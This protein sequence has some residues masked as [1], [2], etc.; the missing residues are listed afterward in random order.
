MKASQI[1]AFAVGPVANALLGLATLPLV[2]WL[3]TPEDVG[4]MSMLN[5][6]LSFCLLFC[7]LGL[8]QAYVREFHAETH[9]GALFKKVLLPGL[10]VLLVICIGFTLV[11]G[12]LTLLLTGQRDT[13]LSLLI[14]AGLL[15]AFLSR[16]LSLILRMQGRGL[17]FSLSQLMPR[18]IMLCATGVYTTFYTKHTLM[19]LVSAW[20]LGLMVATGV[21]IWLTPGGWKIPRGSP[22]GSVRLKD[23][24]R[25]GLPLIPGGMAFWGASTIDRVFVRTYAGFDELAVFSVAISV[26]GVAGILQTVFTTVWTPVIYQ[27]AE[28]ADV[29]EI[30]SKITRWMTIAVVSMFCIVGL[31]SWTLRYILPSGYAATGHILASCLGFPLLLTLSE[32]TSVGIGL[33]RKTLYLLMASAVT[34]GVNIALNAAL[35]PATGAGGAAVAT[36]LS[37]W[38]FLVLRTEFSVRVWQ[39][40][41]RFEAYIF[42]LLCV[43]AA[44]MSS[45]TGNK[46][47][48]LL[49]GIWLMLLVSVLLCNRRFI[50]AEISSFRQ[51]IKQK[52][53]ESCHR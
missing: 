24:L 33:R 38:F 19:Q 48:G 6:A 53:T 44:A 28:D 25:F 35:V 26:A 10:V 41:P 3:F 39:K 11:P 12:S 9:R 47:E 17:A 8:D 21:L 16:F 31:L 43:C 5:V 13:S 1:L 27:R 30:V 51:E 36:S 40:T 29:A 42:M 49:T 23:M 32:V 37:F 14:M 34:L 18:L 45:L 52:K 4:R 7:S 2:A 15:C 20:A 22:A 46:A 50:W